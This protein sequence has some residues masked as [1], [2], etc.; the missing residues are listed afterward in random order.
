MIFITSTCFSLLIGIICA[1]FIRL[2]LKGLNKVRHN[3][4]EG[5]QRQVLA[6]LCGVHGLYDEV[7]QY[8]TNQTDVSYWSESDKY[9]SLAI[10][11]ITSPIA[12]KRKIILQDLLQYMKDIHKPSI[13]IIH[14]NIARISK[15]QGKDDE[16]DKHLEEANKYIRE[17]IKTRSNMDPLWDEKL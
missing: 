5:D 7:N 9:A 14:Y 4:L 13:G 2:Y 3:G 15:A 12:E 16:A 11:D 8:L 10:Q 6:Y 17:E 1:S